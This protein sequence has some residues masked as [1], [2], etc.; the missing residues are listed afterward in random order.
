M[1]AADTIVKLPARKFSVRERE[2]L[3]GIGAPNEFFYEGK[4]SWIWPFAGFFGLVAAIVYVGMLHAGKRD[5]D[6]H[7]KVDE[8]VRRRTLDMD[9]D[10][11]A[12][13]KRPPAA[14]A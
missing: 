11:G 6:Y 10:A 1:L 12:A 14:Q 5:E 8:I 4:G 2:M 7:K 9:D 13:D 3:F